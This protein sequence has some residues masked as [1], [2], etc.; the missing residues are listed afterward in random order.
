MFHVYIQGDPKQS[1]T[2]F[3]MRYLIAHYFKCLHDILKVTL[4][5][6]PYGMGVAGHAFF[7]VI[8]P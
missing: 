3:K 5:V 1:T 7:K 8:G 2:Y 6:L 4:N